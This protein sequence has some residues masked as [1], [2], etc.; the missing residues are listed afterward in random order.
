[1]LKVIVKQN[2]VNFVDQNNVIIKYD[3]RKQGIEHCSWQ[4]FQDAEKVRPLFVNT[5][6]LTSARLN[7]Y[8]FD[9]LF[10]E[11]VNE[12]EL[13]EWDLIR[14][15][16][17]RIINAED[18]KEGFLVLSNIQDGYSSHAFEATIDGQ[19]WQKGSL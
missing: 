4:I 2:V 16:V 15:A 1:M 17:F 14:H 9:T 7:K 18:E 13:D 5:D 10:F 6:T 19:E 8:E 12:D 3:T 11:E